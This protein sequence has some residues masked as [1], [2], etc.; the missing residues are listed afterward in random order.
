V[1]AA[2]AV[3]VARPDPHPLEQAAAFGAPA[4]LLTVAGIA[5]LAASLIPARERRTD[6]R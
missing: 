4:Q 3:V 6:A 1:L 5:F 2:T